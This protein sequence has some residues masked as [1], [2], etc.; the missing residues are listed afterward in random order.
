MGERKIILNMIYDRQMERFKIDFKFREQESTVK[1]HKLDIDK[2][3]L[4]GNKLDPFL[5][6]LLYEEENLVRVEECIKLMKYSIH[7]FVGH[8]VSISATNS[9]ISKQVEIHINENGVKILEEL[10]NE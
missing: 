8:S 3:L 6:L 5:E 7:E 9:Y 2:N 4:Q 1:I 10:E